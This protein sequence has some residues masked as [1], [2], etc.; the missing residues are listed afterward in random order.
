MTLDDCKMIIES[1]EEILARLMYPDEIVAE[2]RYYR[3]KFLPKKLQHQLGA[4][5]YRRPRK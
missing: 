2:L 4:V 3:S 5:I 1:H